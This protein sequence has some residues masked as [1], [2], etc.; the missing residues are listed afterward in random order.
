[1]VGSGFEPGIE[2]TFNGL[3]ASDVRVLNP[4]TLTAL[5]P[6]GVPGPATV[7]VTNPG[8]PPASLRDA[9]VFVVPPPVVPEPLPEPVPMQTPEQ[10]SDGS[11]GPAPVPEESTPAAG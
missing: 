1:V 8:Q 9:A 7:I 4:T 11:A 3:P 6:V 10:P 2:V 5:A